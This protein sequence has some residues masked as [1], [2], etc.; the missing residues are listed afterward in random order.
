MCI[1]GEC[2]W[3]F[4]MLL[5]V[6]RVSPATHLWSLSWL[7]TPCQPRSRYQESLFRPSLGQSSVRPLLLYYLHVK[8]SQAQVSLKHSR[9]S[10]ADGCWARLRCSA[11]SQS[12]RSHGAREAR[13]GGEEARERREI[14]LGP[15][16]PIKYWAKWDEKLVAEILI[17]G[18]RRSFW[19]TFNTFKRLNV[20]HSE[21]P[22][23]TR[24]LTFS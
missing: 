11:Q 9:L 18:L 24:K 3:W 7:L 17:T 19:P 10:L 21:C 13:A 22:P 1:E 16:L 2:K 20:C 5:I 14:C 4:R 23:G 12:H 6:S 15:G 8:P